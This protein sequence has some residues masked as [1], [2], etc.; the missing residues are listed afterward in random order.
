MV[1]QDLLHRGI[2]PREVR[3]K[4]HHRAFGIQKPGDSQAHSIHVVVCAELLDHKRDAFQSLGAIRCRN[5][6]RI[7]DLTTPVDHSPSKVG[8]AN[9]KTDGQRTRLL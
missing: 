8:S 9:V 2:T 5:M 6:R 4:P 7:N 3:S 1:L